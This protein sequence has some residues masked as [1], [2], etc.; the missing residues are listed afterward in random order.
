MIS[1]EMNMVFT[2]NEKPTSEIQVAFIKKLFQFLQEVVLPEKITV[3][4]SVLVPFHCPPFVAA[5]QRLRC[6]HS[7]SPD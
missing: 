5:P 1:R 4:T 3:V 7:P 2:R 6:P